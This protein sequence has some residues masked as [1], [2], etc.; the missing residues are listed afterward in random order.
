[1]SVRGVVR[2]TR[3]TE[4]PDKKIGMGIEFGTLTK[5]QIEA[6]KKMQ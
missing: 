2:W 6:L 3:D 5:K 4:S 1:V